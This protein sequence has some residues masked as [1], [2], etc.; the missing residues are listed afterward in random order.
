MRPTSRECRPVNRQRGRM[1]ARFRGATALEALEDRSVPSLMGQSLFP[2]DN[3]WNQKITNAPVAAS[4]AAV[5]NNITSLYGDGRLHP[6][7]GQ[8][9]RST[10]PL[11]GIPFNVVHG[12]T[13]PLVSVVI[14]AYADESDIRS[15]AIPA[16]A[17]IEGDQQSGPTVGVDNRGD[18]HL[19]VYDVDNDVAYEFYR[20]SRP[21]ENADGH[22]H[23]DQE[24]VWDM[25][26]NSFRPL[27]WTSADAAGLP[28]LP[29]MVRP[30]EG[31]P[32][33]E[34]GQGAI[35]HAIRFTL[36][37]NIILN[38]FLYPA[39][40]VAN[41][42]NTNAAVQPPMGSRFRLKA[43][44]DI[45]LL[46]P[47]S[48]VIARAMKDYGMILADNGSNFYFS[49]ASDSVDASNN[50]ALTWNDDDIQDS[51]HGLKSLHFSDFE[52]V[53]LTPAV[54]GLSLAGGPAGTTLTV[55]GRNFSGA[56]GQLQV[57][58]GETRA[59]GVNLID[60]GHLTVIVPPGSGTVDVRVQSGA[61]TPPDP[62]NINNPVFGYGRSALSTGDR[63]TYGPRVTGPPPID[64]TPTAPTTGIG[65]AAGGPTLPTQPVGD[66]GTVIIVPPT[67]TSGPGDGGSGPGGTVVDDNSDDDTPDDV[68]DD[69]DSGE[70]GET[71]GEPGDIKKAGHRGA[72]GRHHPHRTHVAR[73]HRQRSPHRHRSNR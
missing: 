63:F 30:D 60:D 7:F 44:V 8:D 9:T 19:I 1:P 67:D 54:A 68:G 65:G 49:G 36:Q 37:N 61:T 23:A 59:S 42:G 25:K 46:N 18:S 3:P 70:D 38:K 53:D 10:D 62:S 69:S 5:I 51:R 52:V 64:P 72:G 35:D 40:H 22:W 6:D 15:V 16:N 29:G 33:N 50:R 32:V 28:I 31:L 12:N 14:D 57:W 56:A 11:Y 45:S 71:S 43:G 26:V 73:I 2:A 4:S 24:S 21:G 20:A 66:G 17:V 48:Q 47:E 27:D 41:S 39:S 58:F 55:L 13:Q 34:G